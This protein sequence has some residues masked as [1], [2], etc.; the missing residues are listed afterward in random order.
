MESIT[1]EENSRGS[2]HAAMVIVDQTTGKTVM[3]VWSWMPRDGVWP[4][5]IWLIPLD[6]FAR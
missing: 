6:I 3:P 5:L 2:V 1:V 4:G